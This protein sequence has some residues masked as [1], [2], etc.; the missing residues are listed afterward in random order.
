MRE[1]WVGGEGVFCNL[2]RELLVSKLWTV[3]GLFVQVRHVVIVLLSSCYL[4]VSG[5]IT[6]YLSLWRVCRR[7]LRLLSHGSCWNDSDVSMAVVYVSRRCSIFLPPY[8]WIIELCLLRQHDR[9][10]VR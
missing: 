3:M 9:L 5:A 10:A 2:C 4:P 7:I 1:E 8:P 6:S